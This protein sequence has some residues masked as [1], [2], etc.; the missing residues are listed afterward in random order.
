MLC[1]KF[2]FIYQGKYVSADPDCTFYAFMF[3]LNNMLPKKMNL[4]MSL[5]H[6]ITSLL[7]VVL[8]VTFLNVEDYISESAQTVTFDLCLQLSPC[9]LL[10]MRG[11]GFYEP[12]SNRYECYANVTPYVLGF[13]EIT[14]LNT[15]KVLKKCQ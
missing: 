1:F 8:R 9:E 7:K 12:C 13:L 2:I 11:G 4:H 6:V 15:L 3:I 5:F 14:P 10:M